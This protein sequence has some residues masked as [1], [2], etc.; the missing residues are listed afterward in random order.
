M[1]H[2]ALIVTSLF[3][4]AINAS[5]TSSNTEKHGA[6]YKIE[7]NILFSPGTKDVQL[8]RV[9]VNEGQFIGFPRVNGSFVIA[10]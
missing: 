1:F 8:A 9:L 2:I 10:G 4:R 5:S 3:H 7:G 6:V